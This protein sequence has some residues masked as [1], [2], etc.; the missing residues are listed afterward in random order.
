METLDTGIVN[1]FSGLLFFL[2]RSKSEFEMVADEIEN[3]SLKTALNGLSEESSFYEGE[4]KNYL[5][6]LG[7]I[8]P[9]IQYDSLVD[10]N[11]YVNKKEEC[12]ENGNELNCICTYNEISLTEAYSDLLNEQLPFESLK[13][14]IF[15]QLNALKFTFMKIKTLN[16]ARFAVY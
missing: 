6:H 8:T 11:I 1:K 14:I 9:Y 10:N 3:Y 5:E 7:I 15:Y 16:T 13:E 4:L 2:K 12:N